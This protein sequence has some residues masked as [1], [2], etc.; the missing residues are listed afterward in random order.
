MSEI[1]KCSNLVRGGSTFSKMCEIQ[2]CPK[3]RN[4]PK[5][6]RFSIMMP[7]LRRIK[8]INIKIFS[9]FC[10]VHLISRQ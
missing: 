10:K 4:C 3:L 2:K 5:F 9:K 6:S 8:P 1:Q 7:P